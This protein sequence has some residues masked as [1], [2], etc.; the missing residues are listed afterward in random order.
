[1]D[2]PWEIGR[3]GYAVADAGDVDG[4]GFPDLLVGAP[5]DD[6][7]GTEAGRAFLW[8]GGPRMSAEPNLVFDDSKGFDHFGWSVAGIGDV[9]GD[10]YPDVAVGSP[11]DDPTGA[12]SGAVY[13]YFG[14]P[15][16]DEVFDLK[17]AAAKGDDRFGFSISK[18]GD[19]NRDGRDDF[20][21]GAPFGDDTGTDV[22]SV[23]LFLGA[24]GTPSASAALRFD[25]E[26]GGSSGP[27]G[28]NGSGFGWA[29][30]D[31]P[32]FRGDGRAGFA[33][34]APGYANSTGRAY[35]FFPGTFPDTL[36]TKTPAIVLTNAIADQE[37]GYA[38]SRGGN[39][40]GDSRE[41]LLVG[42]PAANGATGFVKVYY[43]SALPPATIPASS[44]NLTRLGGT[45]GDRFGHAVCDVGDHDGSG[46]NW[47]VG[48]PDRDEGG[49][50]A[51]RVYLFSGTG[52][53]PV[54][55]APSNLSGSG[56][57][58][59]HWGFALSAAGG[60][61]DGDSRD[62]LLIGAPDANG[63]DNAIRGLL[64]FV[65][66]GPGVV[67]VPQLDVRISSIQDGSLRL[68]FRGAIE[69]ATAA[70]LWTVQ[71]A[72][73][74]VAA[75]G[76]GLWW[77][78]SVLRGEV[79]GGELAGVS[80]LE[81]RWVGTDGLR[82]SERFTVPTA[83]GRLVLHPPHPNPFNPST[84]VRF[85]LPERV[86]FSLVVYD[87]RGR[88]VRTLEAGSAG[89]GAFELTFDGRDDAGRVLAS[90]VYRLRLEAEGRV[91][92]AHLIMLK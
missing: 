69:A 15:S 84:R 58:G 61:L 20:V 14:G 3:F 53:T 71:A 43:G 52:A 41:D 75:L 13:V 80:A 87:A 17:L 42:A 37:F 46:R 6:A 11:D 73:R 81:L 44:A 38:V 22:G 72:Q 31:L 50:E 79:D 59:D 23:Y 54:Q 85:E 62:D 5:L 9:N 83:P 4:D 51:G 76:D 86:A 60:D 67:G 29:V 36:P 19:M 90:G 7:R 48:A 25:G 26:P 34:G 77:S 65:G 40:G 57:A 55:I 10:S 47:A 68:E 64:A 82:R 91:R 66:S 35:V 16:M 49:I 2:G 33:V 45:S 74:E 27:G 30:C 56:V 1:V 78:G 12:E 21:V 63:A 28:L 18:A 8:F 88:T 24:N 92:T 89:P 70:S 32:N 39:I